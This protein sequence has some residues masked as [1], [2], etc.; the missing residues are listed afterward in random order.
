MDNLISKACQEARKGT[1]ASRHA[2]VA[3]HKGRIVA[4]AFNYFQDL[5][6][7]KSLLFLK[8]RSSGNKDKRTFSYHAEIIAYYRTPP[9]LRHNITL[10]V[11][12]IDSE[13]NLTN[14]APCSNCKRMLCNKRVKLV[15]S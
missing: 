1:M 13:G 10:L 3:I 12:R 15:Y 4:R 7:S 6:F 5:I 11:I 8:D 14:S 2:C 9:R